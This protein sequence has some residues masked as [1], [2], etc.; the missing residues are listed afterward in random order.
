MLPDK[1][2]IVRRHRPAVAKKIQKEEDEQQQKKTIY[3]EVGKKTQS[4]KTDIS[5]RLIYGT[6]RTAMTNA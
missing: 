4:K 2:P 1:A 5:N 6:F 3:L